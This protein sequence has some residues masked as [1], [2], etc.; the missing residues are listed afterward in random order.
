MDALLAEISESQFREW[1]GFFMLEPWGQAEADRRSALMCAATCG[2]KSLAPILYRP[3][4]AADPP[5][6]QTSEEMKA[7]LRQ[8][9]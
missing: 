2:G 3:P 1:Q 9:T 5:P 8:E 7:A 6:P 4:L